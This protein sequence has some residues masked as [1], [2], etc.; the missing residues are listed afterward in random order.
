[1]FAARPGRNSLRPIPTSSQTPCACSPMS[2]LYALRGD[3]PVFSVEQVGDI[4]IL[5]MVADVK[6]SSYQSMQHEYNRLYGVLGQDQVQYAAFDLTNCV[7][8]DSVMVG[9]LVNLTHRIRD[10]G[11]NAILIGMSDHVREVL[12]RLMLL[13]A[14][15]KRAMWTTYATRQEAYEAYPW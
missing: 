11:G 14:D 2:D 8:L 9:V 13:Q 4:V 15:N 7:I 1:M 12:E 10:R 6:S 3:E 5:T